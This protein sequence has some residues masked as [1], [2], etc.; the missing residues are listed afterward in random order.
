MIE[1][2]TFSNF[3][4]AL[5]ALIFAAVMYKLVYE[6]LMLLHF[7]KKQGIPMTYRFGIGYFATNL[8]DVKRKGDFYY[9]WKEFG[10]RRPVA[11]A[12]GGNLAN[13]AHV[14]LVDPAIIKAFYINH[15]KYYT[16]NQMWSSVWK[17][18]FEHGLLLTEG[19]EW[20]R[21]RRLISGA[22]HHEFLRDMVPDVVQICDKMLEDLKTKSLENVNIMHEFQAITG[23]LIGRLF[24]GEEFSKYKLRGIPVAHFLADLI[25][26]MSAENFSLSVLM[27]GSR[28]LDLGLTKTHR[29][30]L[31]DTKLFRDF[32]TEVIERKFAEVSLDPKTA[33]ETRKNIID[34]LLAQRAENPNDQLSN[35]EILEEFVTFFSAGM[36][37]TGHTITLATYYLHQ[38]PQYRERL[39]QE[40]KE[41]FTDISTITM[42]TLYKCD[43]ATAFMKEV[44]RFQ[45]P[46]GAIFDRIAGEDHK[47]GNLKIKKGTSVNIGYVANNF[48]PDYHD[49]VDTFDPDRWLTAS[50]TKE[51]TSKDPY[52]YIPFSAGSRNCIGQH[53]AMIQAR[54]IF[55]LFL[56]K[57]DFYL[58]PDYKLAMTLRFLYEPVEDIKYKL[59]PLQ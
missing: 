22:F 52:I 14:T 49:N 34:V 39:M 1:Y 37:T 53:F 29:G 5:F 45:H 19:K 42:E 2:L 44:L 38:N 28:F 59:T 16:K 15:D 10:R 33:K 23:E 11:P 8:L 6:P 9:S 20:K 24:F 36:D 58:R 57:Y 26:R 30:I 13:L 54:V 18:V 48:N 21:H 51:S 50:K 4:S 3:L 41:N 46:A 35:D 27:F 31:S 55:C 43:L 17:K 7:Y 47:L 25:A 32:S 12:F 56:K 40:V